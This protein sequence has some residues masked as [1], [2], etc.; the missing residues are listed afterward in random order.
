MST[1]RLAFGL[2]LDH[3]YVG[4]WTDIKVESIL[5]KQVK[6]SG[7]D[8]AFVNDLNR[9]RGIV[10]VRV[11]FVPRSTEI[12]PLFCRFV[13]SKIPLRSLERGVKNWF[14]CLSFF[15][16]TGFFCLKVLLGTWGY[17]LLYNLVRLGLR[18]RLFVDLAV[19]VD[20]A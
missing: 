14:F 17:I 16:K 13:L 3:N 7:K 2:T 10:S 19:G 15:I 20:W 8:K 11:A 12:L 18:R 6:I 5:L 4:Q 1:N 9:E